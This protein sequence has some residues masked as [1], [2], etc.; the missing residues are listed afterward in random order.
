MENVAFPEYRIYSIASCAWQNF[1]SRFRAA[2]N[3]GRL[4]FCISLPYRKF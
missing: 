1:F 2:Y 4:T 3:Q